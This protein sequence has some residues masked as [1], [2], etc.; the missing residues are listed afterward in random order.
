M[1]VMLAEGYLSKS[2]NK[3][4]TLPRLKKYI[5]LLHVTS[6]STKLTVC[7]MHA[8]LIGDASNLAFFA[9]VNVHARTLQL[10]S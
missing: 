7:F 9:V 4:L 10:Y 3:N 5:L 8:L 1:E 6:E 2:G